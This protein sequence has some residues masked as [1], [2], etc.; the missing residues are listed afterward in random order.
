MF[1]VPNSFDDVSTGMTVNGGP[2]DASGSVT[3]AIE[4]LEVIIEVIEPDSEE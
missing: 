1:D 3:E 2:S 4:E